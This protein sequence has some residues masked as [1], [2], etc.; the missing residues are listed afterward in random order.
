[1]VNGEL[2]GE[3]ANKVYFHRLIP[4]GAHTLSTE[5]E[6]DENGLSFR[7]E[8]GMLYFFRQNITLGLFV[9]GSSLEAV[10]VEEGRAEV[11]KCREAVG[12]PLRA[13]P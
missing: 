6:F 2:I 5:S 1:M 12:V 7:A 3:S 10:S 8:P 4:A 9:G 11:M 13:R